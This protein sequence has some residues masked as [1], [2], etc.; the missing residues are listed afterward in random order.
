M[1][2]R[3]VWL[4]NYDL[5]AGVAEGNQREQDGFRT[6]R[7]DQ[8][9]ID[10]DV[11]IHIV[12]V[13]LDQGIS[14]SEVSIALAIGDDVVWIA[15]DGLDGFLGTLDIRLTYVQVIDLHSP[16]LRRSGIGGESPDR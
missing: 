9:I 5:V 2:V 15:V 10:G 8:D 13:M 1:Y 3:V 4:G 7:G 6:T 14:E 11:N 12:L 16:F